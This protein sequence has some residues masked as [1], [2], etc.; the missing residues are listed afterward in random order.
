MSK[1]ND[2]ETV[3]ERVVDLQLYGTKEVHAHY[4]SVGHENVY[5]LLLQEKLEELEDQASAKPD[6]TTLRGLH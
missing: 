2:P 6:P 5:W 1:L 3:L 4:V